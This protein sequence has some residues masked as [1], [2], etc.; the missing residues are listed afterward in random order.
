[1]AAKH[2]IERVSISEIYADFNR[3]FRDPL[4]EY[5]DCEP[6]QAYDHEEF[7]K[8]NSKQGFFEDILY[9]GITTPVWVVQMSTDQ[10]ESVFAATGKRYSK[11]VMR[12]HRRIYTALKV[13]EKFP[14]KI[15]SVDCD[16]YYGLSTAEEWELMADH[17][18]TKR[19]QPLSELG[20][21]H[22]VV[23]LF[24]AGFSQEKVANMLGNKRGWAM[25]RIWLHEMG[26]DTPIEKDFVA[27]FDPKREKGSYVSIPMSKVDELHKAWSQDHDAG[28]DPM[29]EGSDFVAK[30]ETFKET[31]A[32]GPK[33]TKSQTRKVIV[34][35]LS[36]VKGRPAL[37]EAL[38]FASNDGGNL[39]DAAKMYDRLNEKAKTA[40]T[41]ATELESLSTVLVSKD[42]ELETVRTELATVKAE[43]ETVRAELETA[44]AE[45]NSRPVKAVVKK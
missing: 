4:L 14:G 21:F 3:N 29:K 13:N 17:S 45:L 24:G 35:R 40:E 43:L 18:P 15:E 9:N 6:T 2:G 1:M 41:L 11:R 31:G 5:A 27:S 30:Y 20:L 42:T 39:A 33:E 22:A 25:R 38:R 23:N 8:G 12:G 44:R 19:E 28:R 26:A 36:Y 34:E 7:L 16:V 37:E 10:I 32:P